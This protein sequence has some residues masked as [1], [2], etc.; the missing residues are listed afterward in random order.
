MATPPVL[1]GVDGLP[2]WVQAFDLTFSG[3]AA[4]RFGRGSSYPAARRARPSA[5]WCT[6]PGTP[7]VGGR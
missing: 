7:A 1:S 4:I 5:G 3:S 2:E 6:W